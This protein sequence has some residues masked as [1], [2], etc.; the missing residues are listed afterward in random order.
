MKMASLC[1]FP[2][3]ALLTMLWQ[4]KSAPR[5]DIRWKVKNELTVSSLAYKWRK[6][7]ER[8]T[9]EESKSEI[10]SSFVV[11]QCK[12]LQDKTIHRG[13]RVISSI[14]EGKQHPGILL[15]KLIPI[16]SILASSSV[17]CRAVSAAV[18]VIFSLEY[19]NLSNWEKCPLIWQYPLKMFTQWGRKHNKWGKKTSDLEKEKKSKKN[20]GC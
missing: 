3:L 1:R 7:W 4:K 20:S 12:C 11:D 2:S 5:W 6:K 18:K 13:N 17:Q 14:S 9:E 8:E 16:V 19:V 10:S 15:N